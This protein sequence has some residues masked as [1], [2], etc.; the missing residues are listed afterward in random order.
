MNEL[1]PSAW[2]YKT[3]K[4][5]STSFEGMSDDELLEY[6]PQHPS[7]SGLFKCHRALGKAPLDAMIETLTACLPNV[8][9]TE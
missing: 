3:G 6:M 1:T 8:K 9:S 7:V 5:V 2:N 4:W